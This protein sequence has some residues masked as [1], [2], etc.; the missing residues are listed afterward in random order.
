MTRNL[1]ATLLF[2]AAL[3]PLASQAQMTTTPP[4]SDPQVMSV[5]VPGNG[6]SMDQVLA[7]FGEPQSRAQAVGDPPIGRW[8]YAGYSVFFEHDTVLHSVVHR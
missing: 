8:D 1:I 2:A 5:A 3:V 4:A 6:Q 7:R